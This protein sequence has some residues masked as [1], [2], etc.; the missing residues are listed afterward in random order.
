MGRGAVQ[1]RAVG[2]QSGEKKNEADEKRQRRKFSRMGDLKDVVYKRSRCNRKSATP[3]RAF[4]G[5]ADAAIQLHGYRYRIFI[6][7]E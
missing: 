2:L 6:V 7:Y 5:R 3:V 4:S 1:D